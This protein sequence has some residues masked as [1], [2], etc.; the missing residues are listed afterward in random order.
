MSM[1]TNQKTLRVLIVDDDSDH[2]HTLSLLLE[3]SGY[4]SHVCD[5]ALNCMATVERLRPD[6]VLLDLG[7][8]GMTGYEIA[9]AIKHDD[10]LQH[11]RLFAL[12]GHGLPL[13]RLQT[14]M[15]GFDQHL[16]KPVA[17]DDLE[18]ILKTVKT[19]LESV[20]GVETKMNDEG[21]YSCTSCAEQ[22]VVPLDLSAGSEQEYEEEC[23]VCSHSNV[24]HVQIVD[25][26]NVRVWATDE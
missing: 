21:V 25:D 7:M 17:F 15:S 20:H 5:D 3:N 24:I 2:A 16:L 12:T 1:T 4:D 26:G 22:I 19:A 13:D 6:V 8:P 14:K 9:E 11:I 18:T 23:P 10:D